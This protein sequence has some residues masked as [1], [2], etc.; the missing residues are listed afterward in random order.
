MHTVTFL[1]TAPDGQ[2][3]VDLVAWEILHLESALEE[4]R[5][6][7]SRHNY[8]II[9]GSGLLGKFVYFPDQGH[10]FPADDLNDVALNNARLTELLDCNE[11]AAVA[12]ALKDY[13]SC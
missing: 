9:I 1:Y 13:V 10:G 2:M 6:R 3:T 12:F 7:T 4:L 5:V 11:A 8:D